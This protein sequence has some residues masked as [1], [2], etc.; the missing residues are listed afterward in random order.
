MENK[1]HLSQFMAKVSDADLMKAV[2]AH[3]SWL[4]INEP[5]IETSTKNNRTIADDIYDEYMSPLA[6]HRIS[7]WIASYDIVAREVAKRVYLKQFNPDL[8]I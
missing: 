8:V 2:E 7:A 1:L 3:L 5:E 6:G 4:S